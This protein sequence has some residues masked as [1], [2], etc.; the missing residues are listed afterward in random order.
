MQRFAVKFASLLWFFIGYWILKAR[1]DFYPASFFAL[2]LK[3]VNL[4][5]IT[6]P[7]QKLERMADDR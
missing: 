2:I 4:R 7:V 5:L 3:K 1:L 6:S